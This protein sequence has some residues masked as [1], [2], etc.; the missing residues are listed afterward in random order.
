MPGKLVTG[1]R[2]LT[3][4][5]EFLN[6]IP[7]A[8]AY[9]LGLKRNAFE[10]RHSAVFVAEERS[11]AAQTECLELFLD[12]LPKRYP[13]L[14][15][16]EGLGEAQT[17]TVVLTGETH[18]VADYRARPLELC[19]RIA[20]EDL[21][22]MRG[23]DEPSSDPVGDQHVMTAAAVVFSFAA[24]DEKLS[25]PLRVIHAPVP[26]FEKDMAKLLNRTFNAIDPK[27][28]LW[29]NNWGI[30]DSG[31]LE[32]S[33]GT[34]ELLAALENPKPPQ[35]RWLKVEYETLRRLPKSNNILFTIK[36][37]ASPLSELATVPG[38]AACLI[39]SL[40][41]MSQPMRGYKGVA[42]PDQQVLTLAYLRELAALA[43]GPAKAAASAR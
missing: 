24:L 5:E 4:A 3:H 2:R 25:A 19:G 31:S 27:E 38:G 1:L 28:P 21:V 42:S 6:A 32:P 40:E 29:R 16:L 43:D 10:T 23:A 22:L 39:T 13:E 36:G 26:G 33:Y 18:R 12:Y 30:F 9:E 35:E 17:I 8:Q 15:V 37:F 7:A 20:Q 34:P 41:G 11:L 14:Y